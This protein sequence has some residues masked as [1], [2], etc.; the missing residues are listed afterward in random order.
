MSGIDDLV[1]YKYFADHWGKRSCYLPEAEEDFI[2]Q[3]HSTRSIVKKH[4]LISEI[5]SQIVALKLFKLYIY[6][7][8]N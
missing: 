8:K 5:T 4:S 7:Q 1:I 2:G 3:L 6:K